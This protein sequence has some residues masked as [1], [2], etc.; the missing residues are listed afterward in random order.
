M[1]ENKSKSYS[2]KS[3][4][5]IEKDLSERKFY[6][7][8]DMS[9][10]IDTNN[11]FGYVF[12]AFIPQIPLMEFDKYAYQED[13]IHKNKQVGD[14][15][16]ENLESEKSIN[17]KDDDLHFDSLIHIYQNIYSLIF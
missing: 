16:L 2:R 9:K 10:I 8:N 4:K 12:P 17:N 14:L 7:G 5:D 3:R 11:L 1:S 15:P 13:I 6:E